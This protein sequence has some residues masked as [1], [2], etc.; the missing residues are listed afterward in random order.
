MSDT[1]LFEWSYA[2]NTCSHSIRKSMQRSI[3]DF[4]DMLASSGSVTQRVSET[5]DQHNSQ[6]RGG[7]IERD[8]SK[9]SVPQE[10]NRNRLRSTP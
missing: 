9:V 6:T 7:G 5:E 3:S 1:S 4:P 2:V 8:S 10:R